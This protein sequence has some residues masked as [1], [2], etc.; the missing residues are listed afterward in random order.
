MFESWKSDILTFVGVKS[1][2]KFEALSYAKQVTT[3]ITYKV[4]FDVSPSATTQ[5]HL[6]MVVNV[7]PPIAGSITAV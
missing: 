2:P 1:Y 7:P 4:I 3:G 6:I 5:E